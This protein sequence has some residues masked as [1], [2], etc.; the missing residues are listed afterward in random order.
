MSYIGPPPPLIGPS[1]GLEG[2]E[3]QLDLEEFEEELA[4]LALQEEHANE[5]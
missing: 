2:L 5:D 1:E 3:N 4:N